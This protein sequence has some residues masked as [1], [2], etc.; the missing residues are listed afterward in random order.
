MGAG[1]TDVVDC[2][3]FRG[4][5]TGLVCYTTGRWKPVWSG[6]HIGMDTR[7]ECGADC[8]K[9]YLGERSKL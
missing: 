8:G 4:G 9:S 1:Q 5:G 2:K 6:T 3:N 7:E